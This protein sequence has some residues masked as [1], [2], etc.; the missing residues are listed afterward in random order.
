[1]FLSNATTLQLELSIASLFSL[2]EDS[3]SNF[4][5]NS[6]SNSHGSS[7]NSQTFTFQSSKS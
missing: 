7:I 2:F 4:L 6:I 5:E 1:M 3:F